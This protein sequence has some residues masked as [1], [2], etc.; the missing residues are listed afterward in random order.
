MNKISKISLIIM[1]SPKKSIINIKTLNDLTKNVENT[2][3]KKNVD[4]NDIDF[5]NNFWKQAQI[6]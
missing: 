4:M 2:N 1:K 5:S 6:K 3:I